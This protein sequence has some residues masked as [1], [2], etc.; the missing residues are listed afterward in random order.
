MAKKNEQAA[1]IAWYNE[2]DMPTKAE[3][4]QWYDAETGIPFAG[5]KPARYAPS[6]KAAEA[7]EVAKFFGG[8][9]L[10][11][12]AK[13]KDWAE[14]IR[15]SK[16][17]EMTAEE[18]VIVC[19]PTGIFTASKFWIENRN[20]SASDIAAFAVRQKT[21]LAAFRKVARGTEEAERIAAEYNALT[22]AWGF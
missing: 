2:A 17:E 11:G 6:A 10:T 3:D 22:A 8:K 4:G 7:R 14:K 13:Q 18:A 1:F 9:A 20:R 12:T 19:N 5:S 21:L 15:A 16:L